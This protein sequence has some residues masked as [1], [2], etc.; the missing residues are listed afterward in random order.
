VAMSDKLA[1]SDMI[2]KAL[3]AHA[4]RRKIKP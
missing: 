1:L 4:K 3:E 2:R